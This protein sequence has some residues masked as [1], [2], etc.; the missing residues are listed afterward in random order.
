MALLSAASLENICRFRSCREAR[1]VS[2]HISKFIRN[3]AMSTNTYGENDM[4]LRLGAFAI[5]SGGKKRTPLLSNDIRC[6]GAGAHRISR[7]LHDLERAE[8]EKLNE[9]DNLTKRLGGF[10]MDLWNTKGFLNNPASLLPPTT[11]IN[12]CVK[13]DPL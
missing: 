12:H 13:K 3:V 8:F 2:Q 10:F 4:V 6:F 9:W 7:S 11:C 1:G 5:T